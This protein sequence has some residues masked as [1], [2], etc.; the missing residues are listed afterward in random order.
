M[1]FLVQYLYDSN[2]RS[3]AI[4]KI[5]NYNLFGEA[6]DLP[7]VAHCETIEARST[8]HDWEFAAH[9][10]ARL[11]QILLVQSGGGTASLEGEP[12]TLTP[13]TAVNVPT[14]VV[15][16]YAFHPGT[17][18]LVVTFATEMLDEILRPEEGIR[19]VLSRAA[20][21]VADQ[22]ALTTMTQ[23]NAVFASRDFARA[24]MLRSLAG[25]LFG[26]VARTMSR[27]EPPENTTVPE[28]LTRF[29]G[30]I[31]L[32]FR[33]HWNVA[34]YAKEL[35][36]SP[37]HL[38]RLAHVATGRPASALIEE[39]LIR[40]AKRNLV[41]TNL[42]VSRIAYAL[43]FEDPAYFTRVFSRATD[44]SPRAFRQKM[45]RGSA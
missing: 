26:Q 23:I 14:G 41:Y 15:H 21:M 31:D 30:L 4:S 8:L 35:A 27:S 1:D 5:L 2:M 3:A 45:N 12:F 25:L 11:H 42:P 22:S 43:G 13:M 10:H 33:D 44:M 32:Y 17:K 19:H 24:Q 37:T 34:A 36:I 7:D 38:S 6:G 28:I 9:R 40:E 16:S 29:Q 39:R 18:G 20:I